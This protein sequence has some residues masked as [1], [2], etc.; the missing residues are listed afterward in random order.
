MAILKPEINDT[1]TT[2]GNLW[3]ASKI[4]T[5]LSSTLPSTGGTITG[6]LIVTGSARASGFSDTDFT[7]GKFLATNTSRTIVSALAGGVLTAG[8]LVAGSGYVAATYYN[9]PLTGGDGTNAQA[10]IVVATGGN[11]STT[12][13]LVAGVGYVTG[14]YSAVPLTG[15]SG[16]NAT[17][18][19]EVDAFGVVISVDILN[20]GI[21]YVAGDTLSVDNANLGGSGSGFSID[22][23]TATAL[24]IVTNVAIT[25]SG[26]GYAVGNVLTASNANLGGSGSGFSINVASIFNI[27]VTSVNSIL[28]DS[29][30]NV[31][32]PFW[33][34]TTNSTENL[35]AGNG[36]IANNGSLVTY[37]LPATASIGDTFEITYKGAGGWAVAQNAGQSIRLG[38]SITTTGVGGSLASTAAGDTIKF[39]CITAN[40]LFIVTSVIGTITVV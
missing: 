18:D 9:V 4:N 16:T 12:N 1:A 7:A 38:N 14:S 32:T 3:S 10:T 34:E 25:K 39:T 17:A 21:N 23:D 19:I 28:P 13:N 2:A 20:P 11:I 37:T 15:G 29:N 31:N 24:G 36:Y 30:G 8:T 26:S 27:P 33:N 35:S 22:V 40:T 6:N 5:E